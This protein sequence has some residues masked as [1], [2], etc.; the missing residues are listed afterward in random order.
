MGYTKP[1]IQTLK[2]TAVPSTGHFA[3]VGHTVG[4]A[5]VVYTSGMVGQ[6]QDGSISDSY[7]EQIKQSLVN[8]GHC[9]EAS[10]ATVKDVLKLTY[11]IAKYD[12]NNRP[13][14]DLIFEWLKGHRPA[15]AL[16]PV[17]Y[18]ANP[19]FLFE[20]EAVAA[21]RDPSLDTPIPA[22]VPGRVQMVDVVVVGAGLSGLQ[23][24]YDLQRAGYKTVVLEARDRV[25]GKTWTVPTASGTGAIDLG[26]AWI[27]DTNQSKMWSLGQRFGMK[28]TVQTI[29]GDCALQGYGRFPFGQLPPF[30]SAEDRDNFVRFRDLVETRCQTIDIEKPW[31]GGEHYDTMTFEEFAKQSGALPKTLEYAN[32]WIRAMLGIDGCEISALYFLHYC[33]SGGGFVQMRSDGKHGGQHLRSKTGSQPYSEGLAAALTPGSVILSSP[34]ASI[35][36]NAAGVVVSTTN[37][38]VFRGKKVIVSVPTPLY[39]DLGFSPPLSGAKLALSSSTRLGYFAKVILLYAE[40]WWTKAGLVGLAHS[41]NTSEDGKTGNGAGP[42]TL[43]R[44]TSD[45]ESGV[46]ALTCFVLANVGRQWSELPAAQRRKEV[47]QQVVQIYADVDPKLIY[48]PVEVFEQEWSKEEFSKGCPCPVT[49]PGV[50]SSVGHA[51]REPF[52]NVH[53]VGTETSVVW[54]GYME[55]AVRSGER[56]AAEVIEALQ[57]PGQTGV[58]L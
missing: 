9:L 33:K 26:A 39:R 43:I 31:I 15:T 21:V 38:L 48:A 5:R 46:Y 20:I 40:P 41:F 52:G 57:K 36:Q 32:L 24:A 18:L 49:A 56:G 1:A 4:P 6:Y 12:P 23:A 35:K 28:Y 30:E 7:V 53:F 13:H 19:K 25:G 8:L 11:Y 55:G 29:E 50:L 34:V 54:K 27:N 45:P 47:L 42:I 22:P 10:G 44:D 16:V 2:P 37:N 51:I 3:H 17:P 58:R 14:A